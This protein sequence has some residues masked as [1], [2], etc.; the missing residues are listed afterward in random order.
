MNHELKTDPEAFDAVANGSKTHEIR[1]NDRR[2]QVGDTLTLRKTVFTGDQMRE[3]GWPLEY[4]GEPI[5]RTVS[6]VLEGYGL[7]PG[8]VV[9][10]F[11]PS[12]PP[13]PATSAKAEPSAVAQEDARDAA[14]YRWLREEAVWN[15]D[16]AEDHPMPWCVRG[17]SANDCRPCDG[18]ELD[19][20][21][22]AAIAAQADGAGGPKP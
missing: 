19:T 6:H 13:A 5:T 15:N 11:A 17:I 4:V 10:S 16:I 12:S 1:H 3:H 14:R 8:W 20:A 9:L 2:F 18:E 22:D 7:M 21:V